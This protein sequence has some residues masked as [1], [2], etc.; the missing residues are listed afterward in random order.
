MPPVTGRRAGLQSLGLGHG[1][2]RMKTSVPQ[3]SVLRRHFESALS[4]EVMG[5]KGPRPTD[6]VLVRHYDAAVDAEVAARM[7]SGA[8]ASSAAPSAP[9]TAARPAAP[10]S[11]P[12]AAAAPA[13][14]PQRPADDGGF[15]GWLKRL[16][17][18]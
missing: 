4:Y 6:S 2:E 10:P 7:S 17:G 3:D 8:P 11:A 12:A 14:E 9:P 5:D 13:A 15:F 18:G 1:G 16:F